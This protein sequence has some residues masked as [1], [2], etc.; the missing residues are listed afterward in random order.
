MPTVARMWLILLLGVVGAV[1]CAALNSLPM[2]GYAA[3]ILILLAAQMFL[4]DIS[5]VYASHV[6]KP[7][8]FWWMILV[9]PGTILH[10]ISHAAAVIITGGELRTVSLFKPDPDTGTLG[11][12]EYTRPE[13]GMVVLRDMIVSM[14]PFFG[15]GAV[16]LACISQM[17][18]GLLNTSLSSYSPDTMGVA[19]QLRD[20]AVVMAKSL[21]SLNM[22]NPLDWMLI[23]LLACFSLGAAPSTADFKSTLKTIRLHPYGGIVAIMAIF[24]LVYF[25]EYLTDA[26]ALTILVVLS[27]VLMLMAALV[28]LYFGSKCAE[29]YMMGVL[30]PIISA[31]IL[32]FTG[33]IVVCS[34]A[35]IVLLYSLRALHL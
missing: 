28:V 23:Y 35:F 16:I 21:G 7:F 25:G 4:K 15:C 26:Y 5:D 8:S 1:I 24:L 33:D 27:S 18:P 6:F 13:D 29:L 11:N 17:S 9:A 2:S 14:A 3:L 22:H 10:E 19:L 20:T 32:Y 12:V 30:P 31:G 34:I